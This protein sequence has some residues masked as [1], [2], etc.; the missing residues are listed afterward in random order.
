MTLQIHTP[1]SNAKDLT[2]IKTRRQNRNPNVSQRRKTLGADTETHDGN[3]F[4]FMLSNGDKL[5]YPNITFDTI[6]KFLLRYEGCW[7]FFYNLQFDA[8]C[9]LKLLPRDT[10][11]IYKTTKLLNF[12]YNGYDI[13]YIPK[14]Q[15]TIRK[16]SHSISLYDIAQY[17]DNKNL[18]KAYSEHIKKPLDQD[19]LDMKESRKKFSLRYFQRNKNQ[20]RKYCLMDCVLTLELADY[21]LDTFFNAYQFYTAN[22]ISSGY[23]AEK[24]LI[25][26]DIEIALFDD[27]PY[28]IQDLA[29]KSF[30]GGRFEL[31]Q[32]GYIGECYIYDINSAYPYALTFL[33][34][35]N[36][37][38]WFG[39]TRINPKASV[40]F[41]HIRAYVSDSVKI[42]PFPFRT[43]SNRI[44]YPCGEFETFVTLEE[45]KAVTGDTRIKY[46]ILESFQFVAN[47]NCGYP[48]R[49]FIKS[50]YQKRLQ[51]KQE[52]NSL[53][54]AIK[55]I[56]N[57]VYGKMAQRVNNVMGNLFNPVISAYI[58]GFARA[59]LYKFVR[60]NNIEKD[61][62]AFATDSIACRKKIHGL[63][64]KELGEMKLDKFGYDTYFLSNGFYYINDTWK[65]RGIGYD[66]ERK[67]EIQHL[68]TKIDEK[69]NLYITIQTTRTPHIKGAITFNKID[70]IGK[71]ETYDKKIGLNSDRK[72]MWFSQLESLNDK[73]FCDSVPIPIDLVGDIISK[74]DV[75][76]A[77]YD[78]GA[79]D[80]ESE[81]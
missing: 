47:P 33:P 64:S 81:L 70:D 3:I 36:D 26:N 38:K 2:F 16:G 27:I 28:D 17:Y 21:W 24:V 63:D 10:L 50:Q 15:L 11:K 80:P 61:V 55:I 60:E 49:D 56:L 74:T 77:G 18:V 35:I 65:N 40:G 79:Y 73:K 19:Y 51:L 62:V 58:T 59:Q 25:F 8:E 54:R 1:K 22:W 45:L 75:I 53:E 5:E 29:W 20:M 68:D 72:R 78:E 41:F 66:T 67:I 43:K 7:I 76:W 14:K 6:A 12:A 31:I 9:I 48:F 42:A 23:L 71:I 13:R 52:G 44:I 34:D 30:Y 69:G 57:S 39:S 37:G 4:L 32:R 46:K